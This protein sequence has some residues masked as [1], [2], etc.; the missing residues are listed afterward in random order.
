MRAMLPALWLAACTDGG[1]PVGT[2]TGDVHVAVGAT[3]PSMDDLEV[4]ALEAS[5][6]ALIVDSAGP[7]GEQSVSVL[8]DYTFRPLRETDAF[9][10]ELVRGSH[11]D[12][13]FEL[14]F[15]WTGTP[16]FVFEGVFE[17]EEEGEEEEYEFHLEVGELVLPF[18]V[19]EL[20][21]GRSPIAL[22]LQLEPQRWLEA[23]PT[24]EEELHVDPSSGALYEQLVEAILSTT[25]LIAGQTP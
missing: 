4:E 8:V 21:V 23:L 2:P 24:A 22:R 17:E 15:G 10:F 6:D 9:G 14:Q 1:E 7:E 19:G 5:L 11:E 18:R 12:V 13:Q 3:R 16:A 25:T 20:E